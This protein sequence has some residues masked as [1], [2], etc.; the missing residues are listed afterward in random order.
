MKFLTQGDKWIH[1]QGALLTYKHAYKHGYSS[2][3][4]QLDWTLP[5]VNYNDG[6]R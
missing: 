4:D 2:I 3:L 1:V 6:I 5:G